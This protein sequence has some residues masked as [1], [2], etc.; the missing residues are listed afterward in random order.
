MSYERVPEEPSL[1]RDVQNFAL[2]GEQEGVTFSY[3]KDDDDAKQPAGL[4]AARFLKLLG[5]CVIQ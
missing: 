5:V 4:P 1:W 3:S 2:F